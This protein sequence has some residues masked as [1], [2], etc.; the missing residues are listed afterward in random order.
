MF[1]GCTK[2]QSLFDSYRIDNSNSPLD[3]FPKIHIKDVQ[4]K[5]TSI[6]YFINDTIRNIKNRIKDKEGIPPELQILLLNN[7]QLEDNKF[8]K[9]Y[10]I[11]KNTTLHLVL[12]TIK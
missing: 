12:K 11:K 2:I 9:D 8:L 1:D 5:T 10:N 3:N 4:G 7:K 6:Y